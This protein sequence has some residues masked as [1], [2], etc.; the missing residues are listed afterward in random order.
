MAIIDEWSANTHLA[1]F[2]TGDRLS[3]SIEGWTYWNEPWVTGRDDGSI[4]GRG[5]LI[6]L[7]DRELVCDAP[8]GLPI[9]RTIHIAVTFYKHPPEGNFGDPGMC[10]MH[11]GDGVHGMTFFFNQKE[12][13]VFCFN[14]ATLTY[15][16][17]SSGLGPHVVSVTNGPEGQSLYWDGVEVAHLAAIDSTPTTTI[18]HW[19]FRN[20]FPSAF[21]VSFGL[22]RAVTM[23]VQ[24]NSAEVLEFATL[25]LAGEEVVP[26][27]EPGPS[28]VLQFPIAPDIDV[29]F[30]TISEAAGTVI[31][32][33]TQI[34]PSAMPLQCRYSEIE[35][36]MDA[37]GRKYVGT[38]EEIS[39]ID[40]IQPS[41]PTTIMTLARIPESLRPQGT[42]TSFFSYNSLWYASLLLHPDGIFAFLG[43]Q[44]PDLSGELP[45]LDGVDYDEWHTWALQVDEHGVGRIFLDGVE[46]TQGVTEL[47]PDNF[48][49]EKIFLP[50]GHNL[51]T[52]VWTSSLSPDDVAVASGVLRSGY[53]GQGVTVS[54]SPPENTGG[55]AI[56]AYLVRVFQDGAITTRRVGVNTASLDLSVVEGAAI[57]V[58]A[59]N[60]YGRSV[61]VEIEIGRSPADGG[62][63]HS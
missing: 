1:N 34:H 28:P 39:S 38:I 40:D 59:E 33:F 53:L 56:Q 36:G 21:G 62:G 26:P 60:V 8:V 37:G 13:T 4:P 5:E 7:S 57:Q 12:V 47:G 23:D 27:V 16:F 52:L 31:P 41:A 3:G 2:D 44:D 29:D 15:A 61:P 22:I 50:I 43:G 10:V 25:E 6:M 51:R 63:G 48:Y 9:A 30:N 32:P 42:N 19:A 35:V 58:L 49:P 14:G 55:G 20:A 18:G 11:A 17:E 24:Q 46:I 45:V 54:W